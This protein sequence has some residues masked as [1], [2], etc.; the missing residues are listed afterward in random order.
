ML[1]L[2]LVA[3]IFLGVL[4]VSFYNAVREYVNVLLKEIRDIQDRL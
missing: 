3:Q 4:V 1:W 2:I